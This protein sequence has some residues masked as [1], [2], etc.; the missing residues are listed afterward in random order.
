MAAMTP[1]AAGARFP[2]SRDMALCLLVLVAW[3]A[4]FAINPETIQAGDG[5]GFD[6][7]RYA[8]M[9]TE[10]DLMIEQGALSTYYAQRMLPALIVRAGLGVLGITP[11]GAA[12]INGFRVLNIASLLVSV[13]F[14]VAVS[15]HLTFS[16]AGFWTGILGIVLIFPNARQLFF[17]P[18]LTDS[19]AFAVAL[20]MVWA[21]AT[22][23]LVW[24]AGLTVIGALAW[25]MAAPIGLALIG[26]A[27]FA[28]GPTQGARRDRWGR[29]VVIA[30]AAVF[31]LA[32]L[33][34]GLPALMVLMRG[35]DFPERG[36][37]SGNYLRLWT[38]LPALAMAG[39]FS[40]YLAVCVVTT[41]WRLAG[42]LGHA[43]LVLGLLA[44]VIAIPRAITG[45]VA[46][47]EIVPEG[48]SSFMP[49]LRGLIAE[50]VRMGLVMLPVLSHAV[51]YGPVFLLLILRWRAVAQATVAAGPGFVLIMLVFALFSVFAELRFTFMLWPFVVVLVADV[52]SR[53]GLPGPALAVMAGAGAVLSKAWL[54]INVAPWPD[55]SGPG[56]VFDWPVSIYFSSLG[57][58][59]SVENFVLQGVFVALVFAA[60]AFSLRRR[61][62]GAHIARQEVH[63]HG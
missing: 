40:A 20:G 48:L 10:I 42:G 53:R 39:C 37:L 58:W 56:Y 21:W 24:L 9:V 29:W 16:R 62:D 50:R 45:A 13:G 27:L 38:N 43:A 46:N 14:W 61:G 4:L 33:A 36:F 1:P 25:Q 6:G 12:I 47:P 5:F 11:D 8:R 49:I 54:V 2:D 23:R 63:S 35:A 41:R 52:V 17:N 32:F 51:Y 26:G 59:M 18:V 7:V 3:G 31:A 19:F 55:L 34:I 57:P 28:A 30:L 15:R 44:A 60:L 22:R